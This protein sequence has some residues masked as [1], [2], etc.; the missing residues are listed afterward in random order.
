MAGVQRCAASTIIQAGVCE[1]VNATRNE[2]KLI[3][4]GHLSVQ[5]PFIIFYS[6]FNM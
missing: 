6:H 1:Y 3:F 4:G 5:R 2:C